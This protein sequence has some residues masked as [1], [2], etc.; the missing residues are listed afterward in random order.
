M[1]KI[2][3][4][5]GNMPEAAAEAYRA[6]MVRFEAR[7]AARE[8]PEV[9]P[10]VSVPAHPP[11]AGIELVRAAYAGA[12]ELSLD[13][14]IVDQL[15]DAGIPV[16]DLGDELAK[17]FAHH[18]AKEAFRVNNTDSGARVV[19]SYEDPA[20]VAEL[21]S[22]AIAFH[23][24]K[25]INPEHKIPENGARKFLGYSATD[26]CREVVGRA[27]GRDM[28][29]APIGTVIAQALGHTTS[30]FPNILG[31]SANKVLLGAYQAANPT[32][33]NVF[34]TQNLSNFQPHNLIRSGDFP[35]LVELNEHG[36]ITRGSIGESAEIARLKSHGRTF[37]ISRQAIINDNLGA[38]TN[39]AA[40]AG[41]AVAAY[42]N[43]VA[44]AV[45]M[46]N[47]TLA[48]TNAAVF[49]TTHNNLTASG[50]AIS[51]SSL[52][53]G[54]KTLRNMKS[55][56]GTILNVVPAVL[57]VPSEKETL[58]EQVLSPLV[59]PA[60]SDE[61]TP[62]GLRAPALRLV[63]EP[64]L[65]ANSLTAWYLFG[66]PA[67]G[68]NFVAGRLAGAEA[69]RLR[70]NYPSNVDGVEF[71]VLIDFY[72]AAVDFRFGYKNAGA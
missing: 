6:A 53:V 52:G 21:M 37:G 65:D 26:L 18:K 62:I 10:P 5:F 56:D 42:E 66:N 72:A 24:L 20:T 64:L 61:L 38:F 17:S 45:L 63:V 12:R 57:A 40:Q 54:R 55:I 43:S 14:A 25:S 44:W 7:A 70:T 19:S 28:R 59:L 8:R 47:P 33:L 50:T 35:S 68:S 13:S 31:T 69:P 9:T 32:F 15:L 2:M 11:A 46:A 60:S 27:T 30:D 4:S 34:A 1:S 67:R 49:S 48:T 71:Q 3:N 22:D 36:E 23:A 29:G 16:T 58:A 51:A 41:R 39:M